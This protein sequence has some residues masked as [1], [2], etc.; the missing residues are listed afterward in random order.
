ME[1]PVYYPRAYGLAERA[2]QILQA[3][4]SNLNV[5]FWA[6]MQKSLMTHRNISKT[7]LNIP[8]EP[9]LGRRVRLP[10]IAVFNLCEPILFKAGEK[11]KK[12][13]ATFIIRK[14]LN[15]SFIQPENS[16]RNILVSV[17]RIASV[18][19]TETL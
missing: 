12:V 1:S 11:R 6:F 3:R 18:V 5:S 15:T 14:G 13:P 9:F 16:P 2:V 7:T 19:K 17:Y 8:V 4:R 10:P